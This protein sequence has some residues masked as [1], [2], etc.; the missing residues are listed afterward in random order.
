MSARLIAEAARDS[1]PESGTGSGLHWPA[2]LVLH[3]LVWALAA[4][5]SRGNL[6]LS[7][8]MA[9]SYA[10]AS[11]GRPATPR[12]RRRSPGSQWPFRPTT[13]RPHRHARPLH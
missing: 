9:E 6:D 1:S 11:S 13:D 3:A 2:W 4:W 8:D 12:L 10:W 5:L 7:G